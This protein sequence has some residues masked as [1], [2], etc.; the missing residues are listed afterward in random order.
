MA[1]PRKD[2]IKVSFVLERE[3]MEA[4]EKFCDDTGRTKTKVIE[5]ALKEFLEKHKPDHVEQ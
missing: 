1:N 3:I 2:G 5:M 4:T